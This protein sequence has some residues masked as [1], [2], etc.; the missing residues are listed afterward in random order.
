V[1]E[2]VASSPRSARWPSIAPGAIK[3]AIK[4]VGDGEYE[5]TLHEITLHEITLHE[6]TEATPRQPVRPAHGRSDDLSSE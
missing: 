2:T 1:A 6:I 4:Q 3:D 5:I